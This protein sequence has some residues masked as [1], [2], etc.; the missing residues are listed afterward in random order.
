[1][2]SLRIQV[3][4]MQCSLPC[5]DGAGNNYDLSSLSK[6]SD[7]WE[8]VT[9]TG[10][11]EHYLINVCKSLSPQPGSGKRTLGGL[12]AWSHFMGGGRVGTAL[13]KCILSRD[14]SGLARKQQEAQ[15]KGIHGQS[16][17]WPRISQC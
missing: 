11:T 8:A 5:R 1:M 13:C 7:N 15:V 3:N 17:V 10:A 4:L 16:L 2:A 14:T 12:T 9:R 6:Y